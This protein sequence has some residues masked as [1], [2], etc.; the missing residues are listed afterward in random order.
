MEDY[1]DDDGFDPSSHSVSDHIHVWKLVDDL[2]RTVNIML[3]RRTKLTER[4]LLEELTIFLNSTENV[5]DLRSHLHTFQSKNAPSTL[6]SLYRSP[7]Q[8]QKQL[9]EISIKGFII[10]CK[11]GF[12]KHPIQLCAHVV[13]DFCRL[14]GDSVGRDDLLYSFCRGSLGYMVQYYRVGKKSRDR[15]D[16][17]SFDKGYLPIYGGDCKPNTCGN[18][19]TLDDNVIQQLFWISYHLCEKMNDYLVEVRDLM[20]MMDPEIYGDQCLSILVFLKEIYNILKLYKDG[21]CYFRSHLEPVID[22][23]VFLINTYAIRGDDYKWILVLKDLLGFESRRHL[24]M[25]MLPVAENG[26]D[27]VMDIDRS[28]V[29][30]ES[31]EFISKEFPE[32]LRGGFLVQFKN[33]EAIGERVLRSWLYFVCQEIF[34]PQNGFFTVCPND[35]RRFFPNHTSNVDPL[36]LKYFRF[37]GRVIAIA[38]MHEIQVG[39]KFDRTFFL[40][41]ARSDLCLEDIKDADPVYYK[42]CKQI[43]D[44]DPDVVDTLCLTFV[45]EIIK[46]GSIEVVE[47][48]GDGKNVA[49]NS[50]NRNKY[51]ELLIK[52][53]YMTR[54][55]KKVANFGKGFADI[56][57]DKRKQRLIFRIL[58]FEDHVGMLHGIEDLIS[59]DDWKLHTVYDGYTE[60]DPQIHWFWEVVGEMNDEQRRNLLFFWT[61]LKYLPINGFGGLK[62]Q[63]LINKPD[64]P[65]NY[66]PSSSTCFYIIRVPCYPSLEVMRQKL[67]TITHD[68]VGDSFGA[69]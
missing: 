21:K 23:L 68:D 19:N 10:S 14:L 28:Q 56:V 26:D 35:L 24:V 66:L 31:F 22:S 64:H 30:S 39:I 16:V 27:L 46:S 62:Q 47:L 44:M 51:I 7:I 11:R 32:N 58:E 57:G 3:T 61:S 52:H 8:W 41:L 60:T 4:P 34:N 12:Q 43:L 20:L 29:L 37:A 36:H 65:I 2:V 67:N 1:D 53:R 13:L 48:C 33:E 69:P 18:C 9:A 49:V 59:V 38:F 63:L 17:S 45:D 6:V 50:T 54:V 40:Q 15:S 42:S 25:L 5:E 55:A